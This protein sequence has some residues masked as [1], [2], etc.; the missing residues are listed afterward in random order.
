MPINAQRCFAVY[1]LKRDGSLVAGRSVIKGC[2]S[3]VAR[4]KFMDATDCYASCL[5]DCKLTSQKDALM[6][7]AKEKL[8]QMLKLMGKPVPFSN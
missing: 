8:S 1:G 7:L 3:E 4:S 5:I 6:A 2:G